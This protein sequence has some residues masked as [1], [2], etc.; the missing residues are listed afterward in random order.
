MSDD[1]VSLARALLARQGIAAGEEEIQRIAV[2][3]ALRRAIEPHP[4]T[5][6]H[7]VQPVTPWKPR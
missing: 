2:L 5:E 3:L 7:L 4:E 1:P 6:P